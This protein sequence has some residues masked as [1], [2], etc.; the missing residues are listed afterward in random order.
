[1]P[2]LYIRARDTG[3]GRRFDVRYRRGGRYSK[4]EHGGTFRT[5]REAVIRKDFIADCLAAAK[6]PK[7]EMERAITGGELFS[8]VHA[9]WIASRRSVSEGTVAGYRARSR[10]LLNEFGETPIDQ[11][12]VSD[13]IRWVGSLS[14]Y[15]PGTV[16]LF[17][18][19]LRLVLDFSDL[20]ARERTKGQRHGRFIDAPGFLVA[21]L[22]RELPFSTT[23]RNV[24]T[25]M[26]F[27]GFSPHSLRHRRATLWHQQGVEAVELARRLGHARP[28][29][30]LDVY[31]NVMRLQEVPQDVL[32]AFLE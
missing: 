22:E 9:E 11:I 24:G 30:S 19:Q 27:S 17:V 16:R 32:A 31:A 15:K 25:A 7:L 18:T 1:M 6:D 5:R 14:D 21:A 8:H 12:G 10:Q 13:V 20:P 28:S 23:R 29:M 3:D 4:V 2:T 26:R